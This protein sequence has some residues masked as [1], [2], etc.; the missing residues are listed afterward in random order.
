MKIKQEKLKVNCIKKMQKKLPDKSGK[1][2]STPEFVRKSGGD[3]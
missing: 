2:V 3:S 1:Y